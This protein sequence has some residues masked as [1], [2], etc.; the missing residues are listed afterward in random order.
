[1]RQGVCL[2]VRG[3]NIDGF[4]MVFLL[5]VTI[6]QQISMCTS[7]DPICWGSEGVER[8]SPLLPGVQEQ[9]GSHGVSMLGWHS[10]HCRINVPKRGPLWRNLQEYEWHYRPK[11]LLKTTPLLSCKTLQ[12]QPWRHVVSH[13]DHVWIVLQ[14]DP[15]ALQSKWKGLCFFLKVW[16][17]G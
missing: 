5:E 1:M 3:R 14:I 9:P 16:K 2:K 12:L 6:F 7:F 4:S 10:N 17:N 11:R 13:W 8:R 15:Q